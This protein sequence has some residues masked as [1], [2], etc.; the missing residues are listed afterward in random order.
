MLSIE[1]RLLIMNNPHA[2]EQIRYDILFH[3]VPEVL[4]HAHLSIILS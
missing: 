2:P 4:E 3:T 1:A